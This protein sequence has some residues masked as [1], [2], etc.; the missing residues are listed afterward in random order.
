MVG[1]TGFEPAT[2]GPPVRC[3]T[4]LRYAPMCRRAVSQKP[5]DAS[6]RQAGAWRRQALA[7][8]LERFAVGHLA[9]PEI[10]LS[11]LARLGEQALLGA[12]QGEA[13]AVEQGLDALYEL[14]V[15]G[16]VET[17]AGGIL[18]GPEQLE[19]RLP[20]PQHVG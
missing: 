7:D 12:L 1:A 4:G 11:A 20:V 19:L 2:T 3:A 8:P 13:L 16:P 14:E 18:L 9:K 17:L 15:P 10:Q 5:G 6:R